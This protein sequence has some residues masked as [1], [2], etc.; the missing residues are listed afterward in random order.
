MLSEAFDASA[1]EALSISLNIKPTACTFREPVLYFRMLKLH[2]RMSVK[3]RI[4]REESQG[5]ATLVAT[6]AL[7]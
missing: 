4:V 2:A 7:V 6:I 5:V 3:K 1:S